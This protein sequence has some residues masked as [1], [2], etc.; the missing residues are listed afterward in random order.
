MG[1]DNPV[2]TEFSLYGRKGIIVGVIRDTYFKTLH[3][4]IRAQLFHLYNDEASESYFSALF[5]KISG[6]PK[7]ALAHV[8][9][10]WTTNN[11]GIPFEYH[12]LNQDYERL[13]EADN[14]IAR[15]M[16]LFTLLA[17]FIACMG[18]FGQAV[19]AAENKIK[20]IGIRKVN[21]ARMAEILVLLNKSFIKWVV[22]AFVIACPIAWY[23][24]HK[25]LQNFAYKT[26]LSWWVF[27]AAGTAAVAVAILT[28]SWQSWR[29]ATRNPVEALRYE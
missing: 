21:G 18:L 28:V 29:A 17:V 19:I 7:Q 13:Y 1:L 14:R 15:M 9:D 11:P 25:W 12:F 27:A 4:K 10:V 8:D 22:I 6:D 16:N 20:E 23:A 5:F 3:E 24:M 2:G 26:T